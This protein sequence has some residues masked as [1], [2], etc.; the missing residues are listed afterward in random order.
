MGIYGTSVTY[1]QTEATSR[2]SYSP[3]VERALVNIAKRSQAL[4]EEQWALAKEVW[5]PY[6]RAMVDFNMKMLPQMQGLTTEQIGAQ[7]K[8]LGLY[9][10]EVEEAERDIMANRAVK[11]A[12]RQQQLKELGLAEPATEKFYKE[13]YGGIEGDVAERMG[14]ATADVAQSY[15]GATG[16]LRRELGRIGSKITAD[17]IRDIALQRA[18][19]TAGARTGAR[20]REEERVEDVNWQRLVSAMGARGRATGL[21]GTQVQSG[22]SAGVGQTE[23]S[24][25]EYGLTSPKVTAGQLSSQ[26]LEALGMTSKTKEEKEKSYGLEAYTEFPW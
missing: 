16:A 22:T 11:D 9:G 23:T 8:G 15:K 4:S 13:A 2:T 19:A 7:K 26:A 20:E 18:K 5:E 6:E 10:L 1:E 17:D 14:E 21:A 24:V 25:G 12:L 3:E